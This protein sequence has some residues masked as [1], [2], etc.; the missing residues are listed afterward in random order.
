MVA[1]V[2]ASLCSGQAVPNDSTHFESVLMRL[3]R[4]DQLRATAIKRAEDASKSGSKERRDGKAKAQRR[5]KRV[6]SV[7]SEEGVRP[8]EIARTTV[9]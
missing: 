4:H 9:E 5:K 2:G 1:G 7:E 3:H 8:S 6:G